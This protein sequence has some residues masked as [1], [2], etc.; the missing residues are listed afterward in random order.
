MLPLEADNM[1]I[2]PGVSLVSAYKTVIRG[3]TDIL[4]VK[5]HRRPA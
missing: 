2:E 1:A 3:I 5:F 4:P